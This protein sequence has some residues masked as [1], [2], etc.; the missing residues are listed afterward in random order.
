MTEREFFALLD[1]MPRTPKTLL[2]QTRQGETRS[3]PISALSGQVEFRSRT[4]FPRL[5]RCRNR[6]AIL[7]HLAERNERDEP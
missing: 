4:R 3:V 1:E 6:L 7:E 2:V 5:E